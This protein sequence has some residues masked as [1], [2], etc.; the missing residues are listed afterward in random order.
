MTKKNPDS[1]R[2]DWA[3]VIVPTA[4]RI[5]ERFTAENDAVAP[6]LRQVH[7]ELMS[8]D[9]LLRLPPHLR[10]GIKP[11]DADYD[12]LSARTAILR[13]TV[14]NKDTDKRAFP[15]LTEEGNGLIAQ[16]WWRSAG[17]AIGEIEFNDNRYLSLLDANIFIGTEKA[18][19]LQQLIRWFG[20]PYHIPVIA[21]GGNGSQTIIDELVDYAVTTRDV[22]DRP[23]Y[24]IYAGDFD[25]KGFDIERDF[26]ERAAKAFDPENCCRGREHWLAKYLNRDSESN[27]VLPGCT[28]R[29]GTPPTR[30][31]TVP[32]TSVCA[33]QTLFLKFKFF[34]VG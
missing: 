29:I 28:V 2:R 33:R 8:D 14:V 23:N 3:G 5:A 11:N 12:Y 16:P 18:G 13:R 22:Y 17:E 34:A 26:T 32:R 27:A 10:Y 6:T 20:E 30:I 9:A 25:A 24:F 7:Y 19:I 31:V 1:A 21:L 15:R 4:K